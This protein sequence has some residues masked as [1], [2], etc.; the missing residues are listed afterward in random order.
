MEVRL[1]IYKQKV[2]T[3]KW[4][5]CNR[6]REKYREK[7]EKGKYGQEKNKVRKRE[8]REMG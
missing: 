8:N 1:K 3:E 7:M 2:T 5:Q 6:L 4:R